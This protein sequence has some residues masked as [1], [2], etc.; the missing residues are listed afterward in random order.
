[1]IASHCS[2]SYAVFTYQCDLINWTYSEASVGYTAGPYFFQNHPLSRT[3]NV[4]NIDCVNQP[5]SIWS[6]V[7]YKLTL[8]PNFVTDVSVTVGQTNANISF[9]VPAIA[10]TSETYNVNYTG[11]EFQSTLNSSSQIMSTDNITDVNVRYQ[12][13][14]SNL[15]EAN[16]YNFTV[17]S[18]NCIGSSIS[19]I[20]MNFTTLPSCKCNI[21]LTICIV[22]SIYST[23]CSTN[24]LYKHHLPPS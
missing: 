4:V 5:T 20:V 11:L 14:L 6:N 23:C 1:M 8:Q 7:V 22:V 21:L 18:T 12:I 19:T 3:S 13:T 2:L 10:Y 24:Q 15:E 16:T 17:V 9:T